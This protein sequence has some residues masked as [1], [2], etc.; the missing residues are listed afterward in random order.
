MDDLGTLT[1]RI[2]AL[3]KA[4]ERLQTKSQGV[5][6]IFTATIVCGTSGT[7][8]L[9]AASDTIAWA[10]MGRLV[11]LSGRLLVA[12]VS[13]PVGVLEIKTLPFLVAT[14]VEFEYYTAI[15][16]RAT[17]LAGGATTALQ[18]YTTTPASDYII[19]EQ[20][21]AGTGSALAGNIQ[22]NSILI[23]GGFYMAAS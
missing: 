12:S 1:N 17:A 23:V 10:K 15:S 8:T 13:S 3:E 11:F 16:V 20:Y 5:S 2:K 4:I 22:A 6:G 14:G 21:A 7:I 19:V 18:A 9:N